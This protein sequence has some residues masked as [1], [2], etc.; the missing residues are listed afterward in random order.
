MTKKKKDDA[1]LELNAKIRDLDREIFDLRNELAI[2]RKL[3]KPHLIKAKRREKAR[4]LTSM[5]QKQSSKG[6]A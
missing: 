6:V 5:T 3:E 2:N 1:A 4:L